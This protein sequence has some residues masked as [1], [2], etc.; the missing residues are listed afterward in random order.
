MNAPATI[1]R[2]RKA[3]ALIE[4]ERAAGTMQEVIALALIDLGATRTLRPWTNTLTYCGVRG[5]CT[6]SSN[7]GLI[8]SWW[9][10][11]RRRIAKLE[12]QCQPR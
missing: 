8:S 3:V 9:E 1:D 5:S 6:W 10:N 11:A 4:Q 2:L 12:Q 7:H